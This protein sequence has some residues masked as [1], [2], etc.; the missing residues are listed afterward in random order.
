MTGVRS[1]FGRIPSKSPRSRGAKLTRHRR[2]PGNNI[3]LKGEIRNDLET[4]TFFADFRDSDF[5]AAYFAH[6]LKRK[7]ETEP[8]K[9]MN[10]DHF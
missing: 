1:D 2:C 8:K 6:E 4:K 5:Y 9:A 7:L 3:E 10:H